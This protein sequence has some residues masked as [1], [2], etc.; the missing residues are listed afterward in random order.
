MK[1]KVAYTPLYNWLRLRKFKVCKHKDCVI[2]EMT[3]EEYEEIN[4]YLRGF[5]NVIIQADNR[6]RFT[7]KSDEKIMG[8][9][10]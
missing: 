6:F 4:V 5:Y 2:A 9:K 10:F 7:K 8:R 1:T 3:L